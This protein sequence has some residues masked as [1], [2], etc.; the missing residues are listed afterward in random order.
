V[1]CACAR[2]PLCFSPS[3]PVVLT[4]CAALRACRCGPLWLTGDLEGWRVV[5][6]IKHTASGP[7]CLSC[8]CIWVAGRYG[9]VTAGVWYSPESADH[10]RARPRSA[11]C[12]VVQHPYVLGPGPVSFGTAL[13]LVT[14]A[15]AWAHRP[16]A[17]EQKCS[18]QWEAGGVCLL[19][20]PAVVMD[21]I[22]TSS[23]TPSFGPKPAWACCPCSVLCMAAA[24]HSA[25]L[26]P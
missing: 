24:R 13:H 12:L 3:S 15:R 19:C 11:E 9:R 16:P 22:H 23:Q 4:R 21:P 6:F 18:P 8:S 1:D 5:A 20:P 2:I 25:A 10:R 26:Q 7:P 17:R 14:A